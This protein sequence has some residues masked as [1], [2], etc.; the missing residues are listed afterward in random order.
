MTTN[1][2]IPTYTNGLTIS[3]QDMLRTPGFYEVTKPSWWLLN[4]FFRVEVEADGTVHQLTPT[5]K[6]DGVLARDGWDPTTYALR[7]IPDDE[8]QQ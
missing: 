8:V 3:L 6:R 7:R 4:L 2:S 5:W 1:N